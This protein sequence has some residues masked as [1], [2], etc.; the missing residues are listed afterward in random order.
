MSP[1]GLRRQI[2]QLAFLGF[3]GTTIP[4]ELRSLA[5]EF[6][7]GG[8]VLFA[9]NVEGPEQVAE[10][11]F[12][13]A[14]L[15]PDTPLWV[16]VDQE[17]G[18]VARMRRPFTEWPPMATLGRSGSADLA[19]RFG[20][21][22]AR[23][24]RA[25]GVSLDFAPVVDVLTRERNPAIGDRALSGVPD[26]VATLGVAIIE[27]LQGEGVAGCAKHFPGHGDTSVDSHHDLP[28]VDH[29]PDRFE[30]IDFVP[31]RAA[32]SAGVA[33]I[34]VA[35]LLVPAFDEDVPASLSRRVVTT[36]LRTRLGFENL[37]LT[38]DLG[39]KACSAR[40][41]AT[42]AAVKAVAAG[43]D[44]ILLCDPNPEQQAAALEALVHALEDGTLP[45]GQVEASVARHAR[46]KATFARQGDEARRPSAGWREVVG[47]E[48]HQRLA[49]E[50]RAFA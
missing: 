17:G 48:A 32:I 11:A 43:H 46:L 26:V 33:A 6:A 44:G 22:L 38:D 18:R 1:S 28:V 35:H 21:A 4:V 45:H 9:R 30:Q 5:R 15:V 36:E 10:L 49:S 37:I 8:V 34:M 29:P 12:D 31:F 24:M 23:E 25:V 20:Q 27:A 14:R 40:F 47:C 19:R 2:G 13:A 42:V 41:S 16:A 50:M 39:M 3:A 7:I